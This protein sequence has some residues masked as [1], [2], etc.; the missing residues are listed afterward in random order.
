MRLIL[1][2]NPPEGIK[3]KTPLKSRMKNWGKILWKSQKRKMIHTTWRQ[4]SHTKISYIERIK[5]LQGVKTDTTSSHSLEDWRD[6]SLSLLSSLTPWSTPTSQKATMA[7]GLE[8]DGWMLASPPT[9]GILFIGKLKTGMPCGIKGKLHLM[10]GSL[11]QL[12]LCHTR[13]HRTDYLLL[14]IHETSVTMAHAPPAISP[15]PVLRQNW[16]TLAWLASQQSKPLDV[17]GCPHTVFIRTSVLRHKPTNLLPLGFEAQTKKLSQWFCGSNH[18]T[19]AVGFEAQTGKPERVVLRLNHKNCS[20]Q[21]WGQTG[22]NNWPWLWGWTKKPVLLIS[23]C[24]VQ[25]THSV[26]WPL[27]HP[28]AEYPTCAWPSLALWTKSPTPASI[29]IAARHAA[30]ATYTSWDMQTWFSRWNI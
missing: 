7:R 22:R 19:A 21:F 18:Q 1:A 4:D 12:S 26:T 28:A 27:D 30:P 25:I 10:K 13:R 3:E 6:L 23:L 5:C 29:L 11:I 9:L 15:S 14:H 24:M 16:E 2:P 20:H 8:R 17:D